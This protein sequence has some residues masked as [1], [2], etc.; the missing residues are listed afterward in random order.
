LNANKT[1]AKTARLSLENGTKGEGTSSGEDEAYALRKLLEDPINKDKILLIFDCNGTLTSLS[2]NRKQGRTLLR[3]G[4]H[5]LLRLDDKFL[6]ALWSSAMT[7]NVN[8]MCAK[9]ERGIRLQGSA[10]EGCPG[11]A[12]QKG[13]KKKLSKKAKKALKAAGRAAKDQ[14]ME[15]KVPFEKVASLAASVGSVADGGTRTKLLL[16]GV[17]DRSHTV[18]RSALHKEGIVP[19]GAC[20]PSDTCK[21]LGRHFDS[22]LHRVLL[23]D[24]SDD[25][26]IPQEKRNLLLVPAFD[27][28]PEDR[29][30]ELVVDALNSLARSA[31]ALPCDNKSP[32]DV[33]GLTETAQTR[34]W[35]G[36]M[37]HCR[38]L[39]NLPE[40]QQSNASSSIL[41][42]TI[43]RLGPASADERLD[44]VTP[45]PKRAKTA[46]T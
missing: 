40:G 25:K 7:Q 37:R 13:G 24:D 6:V 28:D 20:K 5:H 23:V 4:L 44:D 1:N 32:F 10:A 21:P 41:E 17:L 22:H 8:A 19:A 42:S 3:P 43:H 33:R 34:V 9:L 30:L 35:K 11:N 26:V 39:Q 46:M 14:Q 36:H 12:L 16:S 27:K 29:V 18:P 31:C 15:S 2:K 38:Q 45:E